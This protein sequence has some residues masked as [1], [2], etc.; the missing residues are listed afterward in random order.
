M[1]LAILKNERIVHKNQVYFYDPET[2]T[3][4]VKLRHNAID[5]NVRKYEILGINFIND[6][7]EILTEY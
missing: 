4:N 3:H 2:K 6:M 7:Y 1:H 5:N